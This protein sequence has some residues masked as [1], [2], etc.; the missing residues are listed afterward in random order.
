[1]TSCQKAFCVKLYIPTHLVVMA[2]SAVVFVDVLAYVVFLLM[3][4]PL[5]L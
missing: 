3:L 4:S 2:D 5:V 1:M